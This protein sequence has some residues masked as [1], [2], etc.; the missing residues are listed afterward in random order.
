MLIQAY[1][2]ESHPVPVAIDHLPPPKPVSIGTV[3][4]MGR[5]DAGRTEQERKDM[6]MHLL[7]EHIPASP[8]PSMCR[9]K[10]PA[11]MKMI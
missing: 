4:F 9:Q 5:I 7:L 2:V 11:S 6:A 10:R 1:H 3:Q 8:D